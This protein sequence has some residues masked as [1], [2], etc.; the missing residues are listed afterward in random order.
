MIDILK[1]ADIFWY[2][3]RWVVSRKRNNIQGNIGQNLAKRLDGLSLSKQKYLLSDIPLFGR[4]SRSDAR[5]SISALLGSIDEESTIRRREFLGMSARCMVAYGAVATL[6]GLSSAL[7]N[8]LRTISFEEAKETDDV[9]TRQRY[10]DQIVRANPPPHTSRIFY[11]PHRTHIREHIGQ[12]VSSDELPRD[13]SEKLL[14]DLK[15]SRVRMFYLFYTGLLGTHKKILLFANPCFFE[16]DNETEV[17]NQ[18]YDHEYEHGYD[19]FY[20]IVL[21]DENTGESFTIDYKNDSMIQPE[22]IRSIL[23]IRAY[24]NQGKGAIIRGIPGDSRA[25]IHI[26]NN[27]IYYYEILKNS[28]PA[29]DV[30]ERATKLTLQIYSKII[31]ERYS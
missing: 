30:E 20:G 1:Y 10:I 25:F 22:I 28:T 29:N 17:K 31:P 24:T 21:E 11:D 4:V 23:E 18:V 26:T 5:R 7:H 9:R 12:L 15:E 3:N 2:M 13:L 16:V 8:I 6:A 14:R 27:L 19:F